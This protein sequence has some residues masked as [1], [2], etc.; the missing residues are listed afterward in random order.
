MT[1]AQSKAHFIS[2]NTQ[3]TLPL[4]SLQSD[5]FC[6]VSVATFNKLAVRYADKYFHLDI[7][8]VY[9]ER[10]ARR[11]EPQGGSVIDVACGPGTVASYLAKARPDLKLVGIDLAEEMVNQARFRV[12]T[13]NFWVKDC[14]SVGEIEQMFDAA[15][16]AFGLSY[17]TDND[18]DR[19]FSSLNAVM[20][21]SAL[22]YLSTIT[23]EPL[24][25]GFETSSSGDAVYTQYRSAGDIISIVEK[26]GYRVD[27]VEVIA[28]PANASKLTQDLILIAQREI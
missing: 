1:R 15:A 11:I 24:S 9:L 28:S 2:Q 23:G 8:D 16:F 26:A 22:L 13:A 5:D 20:T 17:L 7:Y 25:S 6:L 3:E 21:D 19:F 4:A 12:P 10:F 14:R 27:L 18:V